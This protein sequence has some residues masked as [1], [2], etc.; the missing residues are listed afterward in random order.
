VGWTREDDLDPKDS[1]VWVRDDYGPRWTG[2]ASPRYGLLCLGRDAWYVKDRLRAHLIQGKRLAQWPAERAVGE[3][4]VGLALE[5]RRFY[6]REA[7]DMARGL[8]QSLED[9]MDRD[10]YGTD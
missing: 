5:G 6:S 10:L 7:A 4:S 8:L 9:L 2:R 1:P 3:G